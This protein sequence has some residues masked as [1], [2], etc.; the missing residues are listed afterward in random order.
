MLSIYSAALTLLVIAYVTENAAVQARS[1]PR[2]PSVT[3][4]RGNATRPGKTRPLIL[5]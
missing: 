5:S 2:R 1:P 4:H 3:V